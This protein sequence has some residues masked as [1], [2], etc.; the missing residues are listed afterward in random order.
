MPEVF[1]ET[2]EELPSRLGFHESEDGTAYTAWQDADYT[3][4]QQI[5]DTS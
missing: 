4:Q 3:L 1:V 2:N 5:A